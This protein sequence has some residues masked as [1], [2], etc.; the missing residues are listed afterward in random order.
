MVFGSVNSVSELCDTKDQNVV[1]L[2][3]CAS[4]RFSDQPN[5]LNRSTQRGAE[6]SSFDKLSALSASSCKAVWGF[7]CGCAALCTLC[8]K[9]CTRRC[10]TLSGSFMVATIFAERRFPNRRKA[11]VRNVSIVRSILVYLALGKR[12][13]F[14]CGTGRGATN[15]G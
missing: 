2:R 13:S 10:D 6:E 3:A 11:N 5:P 9:D 15:A 14:G 4:D 1:F 12:L 8:P 7:G